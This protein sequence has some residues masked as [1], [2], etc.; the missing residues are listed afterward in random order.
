M[1]LTYRQ[2]LQPAWLLLWGARFRLNGMILLDSIIEAVL[3]S[4]D[5][6]DKARYLYALLQQRYSKSY[7]HSIQEGCAGMWADFL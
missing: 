6:V 4:A 3:L 1:I 7:P 2:I 5:A